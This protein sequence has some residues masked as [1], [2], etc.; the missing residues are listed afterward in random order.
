MTTDADLLKALQA[1]AE[2]GGIDPTL[3]EQIELSLD[4]AYEFNAKT[5]DSGRVW[6][7]SSWVLKWGML[8][9]L[10]AALVNGVRWYS[11]YGMETSA[12]IQSVLIA[13]GFLLG[14]FFFSYIHSAMKISHR[15]SK[16][17]AAAYEAKKSAQQT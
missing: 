15:T 6:V 13:G 2:K 14:F 8:L 11:W 4:G 7:A 12:P 17:M 16:R 9:G 1:Q 10:L 3:K 5:T